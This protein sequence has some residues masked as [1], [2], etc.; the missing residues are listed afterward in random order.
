MIG[1]IA[2]ACVVEVARQ[3]P[4]EQTDVTVRGARRRPP[5]VRL[6]VVNTSS[7]CSMARLVSCCE[8]SANAHAGSLGEA[9]WRCTIDTT[10]GVRAVFSRASVCTRKR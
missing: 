8:R 5:A 10:R 7:I 4:C 2:V 9:G 1:R 3:G 6:P